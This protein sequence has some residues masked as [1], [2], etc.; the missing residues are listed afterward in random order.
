MK[1]ILLKDQKIYFQ[2]PIWLYVILYIVFSIISGF[3]LC[4]R[5][6]LNHYLNYYRMS[7]FVMIAAS[8]EVFLKTILL[9]IL[10]RWIHKTRLKIKYLGKI[11]GFYYLVYC[12]V[13][14]FVN[15]LLGYPLQ[16]IWFS[17]LLCLCYNS[18]IVYEELSFLKTY[19][20]ISKAKAMSIFFIYVIVNLLLELLN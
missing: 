12:Y 15:M 3:F 7:A 10:I 2:I 8:L 20:T 17:M 13:V 1:K 19:D 14:L 11:V 16:N 9:Y 5:Q 6:N 18:L 4:E